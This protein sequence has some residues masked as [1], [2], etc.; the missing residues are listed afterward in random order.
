M[1]KKNTVKS[2]GGQ[3]GGIY[4]TGT[5]RNDPRSESAD[6]KSGKTAPPARALSFRGL[7]DSERACA[8]N[9]LRAQ[10]QRP[11]GA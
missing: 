7:P 3:K 4:G 6:R 8:A 2:G 9:D 1:K 10:G 11:K 5:R